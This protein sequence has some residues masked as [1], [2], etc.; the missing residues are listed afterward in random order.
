MDGV[1]VEDRLRMFKL[2]QHMVAE[3]KGHGLIMGG[4]PAQAHKMV[5]HR[6]FDLE[7]KKKLAK[8]VAGIKT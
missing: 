6:L 5:V 1:S 7:G 3:P 4:G 8:G 2:I